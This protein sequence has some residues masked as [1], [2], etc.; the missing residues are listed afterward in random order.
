[1]RLCYSC[2]SWIGVLHCSFLPSSEN[3]LKF[4]SHR[5]LMN[6]T[7]KISILCTP[8]SFW[9]DWWPTVKPRSSWRF[10]GWACELIIWLDLCLLHMLTYLVCWSL[11]LDDRTPSALSRFCGGYPA[12]APSFSLQLFHKVYAWCLRGTISL[13]D[14]ARQGCNGVEFF[15]YA[16]RN[17]MVK[18]TF[19]MNVV[20]EYFVWTRSDFACDKI[21]VCLCLLDW[22]QSLE[23]NEALPCTNW[24]I[25]SRQA[26]SDGGLNIEPEAWDTKE[27]RK[28]GRPVSRFPAQVGIRS[29][30]FF[31]NVYPLRFFAPYVLYD[32]S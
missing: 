22:P 9:T 3:S 32:I 4:S 17:S 2:Q 15:N 28:A 7:L 25:S 23:F 16:C 12:R 20:V 24:R 18:P 29:V 26:S 11:L 5:S 8:K 1:M 31:L 13:F 30:L 10:V 19:F 21:C 14:M 27:T 6:L